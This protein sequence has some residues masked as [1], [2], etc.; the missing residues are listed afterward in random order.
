MTQDYGARMVP[1]RSDKVRSQQRRGQ[2]QYSHY[3]LFVQINRSV[4]VVRMPLKL[5]Q[6]GRIPYF[7]H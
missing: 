2:K 1:L 7:N 5:E 3:V 4:S 6:G